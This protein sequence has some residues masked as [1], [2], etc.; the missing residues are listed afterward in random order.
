MYY[1]RY[2]AIFMLCWAAQSQAEPD[3]IGYVKKVSGEAW[4][5]MDGNSQKAE[6][7]SAILVGQTL[8]TGKD[9]AMGITFKDDTVISI[10]ADTSVAVDEFLYS[11]SKDQ[12]KLST[13]ILK[14]TLQYISGVIAK[15]KP[16]AVSFKTPSG[17]IGVRGTRFLVKVD[18]S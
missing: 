14:G 6:V 7:G 12:L 17:I 16:E 18:E 15:L 13:N 8:K 1:Q 5:T 10:G 11:P 3:K 4:L 2:L 9:G